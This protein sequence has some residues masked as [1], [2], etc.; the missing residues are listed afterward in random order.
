M[1]NLSLH[2][3]SSEFECPCCKLFIFNNSLI[4]LLE[5]VREH[6]N[7]PIIINS[8]TRCITHNKAINGATNS[9]HLQ[10]LAADIKIYG[11]KAIEVYNFANYINKLG[12]IGRY[13]E[14]THL[15]VLINP[16]SRRF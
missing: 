4:Y 7:E 3:D 14:F 1:G 2:F 10:G 12:G 6:F 11:I 13:E 8:G 5:A 15:D 9:C 16:V